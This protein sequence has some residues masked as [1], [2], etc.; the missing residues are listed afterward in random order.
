MLYIGGGVGM[1]SYPPPNK[2]QF[3][4]SDVVM[5]KNGGVQS[6]YGGDLTR[7]ISSI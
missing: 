2:V 5:K 3:A 7:H 1:Y 4:R 6:Q